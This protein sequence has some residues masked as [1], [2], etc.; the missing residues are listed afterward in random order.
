[1]V[2]YDRNGKPLELTVR[3][4][5]AGETPE[6]V[7]LLKKQYGNNYAACFYDEAWMR[8]SVAAGTVSIAVAELADGQI[9]GISGIVGE[10]KFPGSIEITLLVIKP[11]WRGFALATLLHRFLL[12]TPPSASC[13]S[14]YAHSMTINT[15][16][17][18]ICR[19]LGYKAT[20][21]ILNGCVND[22]AAEYFSGAAFPQKESLLVCCLPRAKRSAGNLY[23]PAP[24]HAY[25]EDTYKSLG[26]AYT[27]KDGGEAAGQPVARVIQN[28]RHGYCELFVQA[29]G[30]DFAR[31]LDGA[32]AQYGKNE[33]QTF[34]AFVNLHDPSCPETFRLLEDRGFFFTG[35]Q[36]LAGPNEYAVMH[37][38]LSLPIPFDRIAVVDDFREKLAWIQNLQ[39]TRRNS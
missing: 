16:S 25:I 3:L 14:I 9:A 12:E 33:N 28:E 17:Q 36:P 6:V 4:A 7:C 5:G 29:A 15:R 38:S 20:G 18:A 11:E 24:Y 8:R 34:N 19:E 13:A 35:L 30:A 10:N 21:I 1:M 2:I 22:A 37:N 39:P 23:A 32:L 26:A 31:L 27:I